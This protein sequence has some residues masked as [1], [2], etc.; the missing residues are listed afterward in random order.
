[1]LADI[2]GGAH[3]PCAPSRPDVAADV[4]L[5]MS[6]LRDL[7]TVKAILPLVILARAI[8]PACPATCGSGGRRRTGCAG[9]WVRRGRRRGP[10]AAVSP[11][12]WRSATR[13]R[14]LSTV[15][16]LPRAAGVFGELGGRAGRPQAGQDLVSAVTGRLPPGRHGLQ[17]WHR[18]PADVDGQCAARVERA[19]GRRRPGLR[20]VAGQ[21]DPGPP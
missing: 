9:S 19:A 15:A 17:R 7:A 2:F 12:V 20:G 10:L 13:S 11:A 6:P 4:P 21:D 8:G 18:G 3:L 16:P 14:S 1:C 5:D